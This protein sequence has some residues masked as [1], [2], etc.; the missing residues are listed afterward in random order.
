MARIWLVVICLSCVLPGVAC[1]PGA[2][3]G[4]SDGGTPSSGLRI[5]PANAE[6]LVVG[7][8][9]QTIEYKAILRSP[10][11]SEEDVTDE[12]EF[13]LANPALGTFSGA[14]FTS[15][16]DRGGHTKV[17]ATARG[18]TAEGNLTV[19]IQTVIV[20]PDAPADAPGKF[21]GTVAGPAPELVYPPDDV[22]VPPNLNELEFHYRPGAGQTLFELTVVGSAVELKVYF[23][24]RPLGT[25]CEWKPSETTW[26]LIAEA[27]RGQAAV[28]YKLRGVDGAG[29]IGT[30]AERKISFGEEDITGGLY[31]WAA[32]EGTIK[33]YDF[34]RRTQTAENY[35][36]SAAAGGLCVG[37]HALSRDGVK[38]AVGLDVPSPARYQVYEV[39]TRTV[40]YGSSG[41]GGGGGGGFGGGGDGANFFAWNP[42]ATQL[43]TSDGSSI[44][45]RDGATGAVQSPNPFIASG[46][47]PDWSPDGNAI[48]YAK[49]SQA[50]CPFGFCPPSGGPAVSSA[51]LEMITRSGPGG[52]WS[53][54]TVLVPFTTGNNY[55]PSFSPDG[56][57]IIF[58]VSPA[59]NASMDAPDAEVWVVP[60]SGG[61]AMKLQRASM[62]GDSWPKWAPT[63]QA[64]RG[65]SLMWFTFSSRRDYG[66]REIPTTTDSDGNVKRNA[67]IWMAAFNPAEVGA[68]P[69]RPAFWLPF[70]EL[71][72][73][74]HIAQWALRV[75]RQPCGVNECP[76]GE[77]CENGRCYPQIE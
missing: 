34:G 72:S 4:S 39:A 71:S 15:A 14:T 44:L 2:N 55:Y 24:C 16:T 75:E 53:S 7:G 66:L 3:P 12:A 60:T 13:S 48:V 45:L 9:A 76:T 20:E 64:Y 21:E 6:V 47:M 1:G 77:F 33:R 57:W 67:Q 63:V 65:G 62:T 70:Q 11:G 17:R 50:S 54:P 26:Q 23:P 28:V 61:N 36:T 69:S 32:A 51:S 42:D 52:T 59:N 46:T 41:G 22:L 73:G 10:G 19:R 38:M 37:C 74:N 8:V 29:A 5:E 43:L 18:L 35:L 40:Q 58:N 49:V 68:D 30:S 31:Y 56:N 25:G 27:E